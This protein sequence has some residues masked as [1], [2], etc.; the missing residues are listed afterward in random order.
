MRIFDSE[1][2]ELVLSGTIEIDIEDWRKN[3]EYKSDY[4]D[5][6][7]VIDWFWQSVYSFSNADRL[8]LLQVN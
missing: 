5:G 1:Q 8:K 4:Y 6:H 2:L 7:V 3:T